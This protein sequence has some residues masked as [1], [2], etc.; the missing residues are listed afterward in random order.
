MTTVFRRHLLIPSLLIGLIPIQPARAAPPETVFTTVNDPMVVLPL[1]NGTGEHELDWLSIGLQDSLTVDLW[2]VSALNTLALP[3]IPAPLGKV[4]PDLSLT[5]VAG[6]ERT[7]WRVQS[8]A[9]LGHGEYLWGEYRREGNLLV[10]RLGW[11]SREG[12]MPLVERE[13]RATGVVELAQATT[14]GLWELLAA[15]GIPVTDNEWTRMQAPKTAVAKALEHNALGYWSQIRHG[16]SS[17]ETARQFLSAVWKAHLRAA[18]QA[19]RD[20]AEAWNNL[21]YHYSTLGENADSQAAFERA[22]ALKPELID[23]LVGCAQ[24]DADADNPAAALQNYARAVALNPSLPLHRELL[25]E[26]Y[27]QSNQPQEGLKQLEVL[28]AHLARYGREFERQA[29]DQW[30][31]LYHEALEQWSPA[32]AA[33]VALN[34]TLARQGEAANASRLELAE[35]L[36]TTAKTL[37]EEHQFQDAEAYERLALSIHEELYEPNHLVIARNLTTLAEILERQ[38]RAE[39]ATSLAQRALAIWDSKR[40]ALTEQ[41]QS[42]GWNELPDTTRHWWQ[43]FID[44]N[45]ETPDAMLGLLQEL[46]RRGATLE[47]FLRAY[48]TTDA[49]TPVEIL[50]ALEQPPKACPPRKEPRLQAS[51][52]I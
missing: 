39:E 38:Q 42:M 26:T 31:G 28:E 29:L 41:L 11:Y 19:D 10:L 25:L 14:K 20:Y 34:M 3:Q 52:G 4:C 45:A 1:R 5:C 37:I 43:A 23:A 36:E 16:L 30:R 27:A 12:N 40:A 21:G 13:V 6:Q 49:R 35:Q 47:D 24:N 2:Y 33:H 50:Q 22:L 48:L 46:S 17:E 9:S 15:R 7:A 32:L 51:L 8:D 44:H 18:V